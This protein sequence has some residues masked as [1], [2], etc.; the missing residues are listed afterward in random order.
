ME[1]INKKEH[2]TDEGLKRILELKSN[3][4]K[5]SMRD[6]ENSLVLDNLNIGWLVGFIEGE[7]C[8]T[9]KAKKSSAYKGGYQIE[10]NFF[11]PFGL[12]TTS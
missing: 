1:L 8:F 5:N 7:G 2:L 10:L 3:M 6:P 9:V 12:C 4:N 11:L